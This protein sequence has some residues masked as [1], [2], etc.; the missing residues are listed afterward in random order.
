MAGKVSQRSIGAMSRFL[1]PFFNRRSDVRETLYENNFPDWF[2]KRLQQYAGQ[3]LEILMAL[4]NGAFF[5]PPNN[6]YTEEHETIE[7]VTDDPHWN[8][9]PVDLGEFYIQQL[10]AFICTQSKSEPVFR[11]LQLDGFDVDTKGLRL[12]PLE[13]PVSAQ[14]EADRL[15]RMVKNSGLPQSLVILKHIE[16]AESLHTDGKDHPSLN[17]SRS[18]VQALIDGISIETNTHGKHST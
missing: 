3:W 11:S 7:G 9:D 12:V 17:E 6:I 2:V 16:D 18:L 5:Y 8:G 4:R 14:A 10:A 15:T 1:P 13:G